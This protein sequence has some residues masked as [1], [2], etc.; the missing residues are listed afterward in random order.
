MLDGS[1]D[2]EQLAA[3]TALEPG[4]V[5]A[6][7]ADL[8][9][10]GVV[11]HEPELTQRSLFEQRLH[12][13]PV[14]ER[15]DQAQRAQEPE[16]AAYCFDPVAK[17]I[18]ALLQNPRAGL[19]HARLIAANHRTAAGLEAL[20]GNAALAADAGVRRALLQNPVLP[21]ALFRRLWGPQRL[22]EQYL[23]AVSHEVPEQ[24]RAMGREL[25]R[26]G[27]TQRSAEEK[28]DLILKCEGRCLALLGGLPVDGHTTALLCRRTYVS[29][30]L[31]QNIARWSAAP[32]P[33]IAH[34]LRQDSVRRNAQL[35]QMLERHPNANA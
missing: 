25:L 9:A 24:T 11:E 3:A 34:L 32:P 4:Q 26:T 14:D 31:I 12:H 7:V 28:T 8:V 30:L 6:M 2:L 16:L 15:A 23:V 20:A 27:F 1:L 17:V 10:L 35:R 21:P 5:E 19:A 13:H 29:T 22:Q 18:L 33:L